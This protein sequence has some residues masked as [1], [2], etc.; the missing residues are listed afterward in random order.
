MASA[1]QIA[2]NRANAQRSTGPK[3]AAGKSVSRRNALTHAAYAKLAIEDLGENN[4]E[5]LQLR[6][7]V[8]DTLKPRNDLAARHADQMAR[9]LWLDGGLEYARQAMVRSTMARAQTPILP[10]PG[11]A[12][13]SDAPHHLKAAVRVRELS[14]EIEMLQAQKNTAELALSVIARSSRNAVV[15]R[16]TVRFLRTAICQQCGW[17]DS[18]LEQKWR[19]QLV[20]G[21]N[22]QTSL[23]TDLPMFVVLIG[24]TAFAHAYPGPKLEL[25]LKKKLEETIA[26]FDR[27]ITDDHNE[28]DRLNKYIAEEIERT[29]ASSAL[30]D[31]SMLA[32]WI[33][34]NAHVAKTYAEAHKNFKLAQEYGEVKEELI[35]DAHLSEPCDPAPNCSPPIAISNRPVGQEGVSLTPRVESGR[36]D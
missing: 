17:E 31:P 12:L 3:T 26:D 1:A 22:T 2:A 29:V 24:L 6:N 25:E 28:V 30:L 34:A 9:C 36:I 23:D 15:K 4:K 8:H 13:P 20:K 18:T 10:L 27:K 7:S 16:A 33:K 19:A 11:E 14:A 35:F 5:W 32:R 21:G